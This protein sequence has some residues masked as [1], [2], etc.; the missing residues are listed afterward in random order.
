MNF[1]LARFRTFEFCTI[2]PSNVFAV[3]LARLGFYYDR[4]IKKV[5]CHFCGMQ[6]TDGRCEEY[7]RRQQPACPLV[8][9][10]AANNVP[11]TRDNS[12][13]IFHTE[14][15]RS[16]GVVV[17]PGFSFPAEFYGPAEVTNDRRFVCRV[18]LESSLSLR[19]SSAR[20]RL[21]NVDLRA[22]VLVTL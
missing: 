3:K 18:L 10:T 7:H 21:L 20:F 11:I 2:L 19:Y 15:L 1:E 17:R 13:S 4:R 5:Q 8:A 12:D 9:G 22:Q 6:F 14:M 16:L